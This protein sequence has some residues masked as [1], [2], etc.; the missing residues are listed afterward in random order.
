[1]T[2]EE[3]FVSEHGILAVVAEVAKRQLSGILEITAGAVEGA[4]A[5]NGGKLVDARVGHLTGF[6]AMNAIASLRDAHVRFDR[7]IAPPP[8]SSIT[9]TEQV[10]LKQFFGIESVSANDYSAP[11]IA[12]EADEATVIPSEVEP[13]AAPVVA[14]HGATE[15]VTTPFHSTDAAPSPD[16]IPVATTGFATAP[17]QTAASDQRRSHAPLVAAFAV[18]VMLIAVAA[19]ALRH[20]FRERAAVAAV[21]TSV[22]P[23]SAPVPD[24]AN[25]DN[26]P[27]P[28]DTKV[29]EKPAAPVA[30]LARV[31]EKPNRAEA[32]QNQPATASTPAPSS[33]PEI[34]QAG[35]APDLTGKWNVVNTVHTTSYGSFANLQ[36]GFSV[37]I[38]QTGRTFT[39]TGHKISENGHVLPASSRTPIQL[40]GVVNGDNVEATFSERGATRNTS[41]RIVWKINSA[42]GLR[43]TFASTAAHSSGQSAA[44]REL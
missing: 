32:K 3:S 28:A 21:S 24:A 33:T 38:N 15:P 2:H 14:F 43:G 1:M 42:G 10:V 16:E 19:V 36:I 23:V 35:D 8:F 11:I 12:D 41:G 25:I 44:T 9:A 22:E 30:E 5:F 18:C 29:V 37:S 39:A 6:Q 4:L 40:K 26:K 13:V 31:N 7:S 20:Q 17:F 27:Q 34:A